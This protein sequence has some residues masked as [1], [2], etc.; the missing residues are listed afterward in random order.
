MTYLIGI[1]VGTTNCK[2][3]AYRADGSL[4]MIASRP[5]VT[6]HVEP[7]KAEFDPDQIWQAVQEALCEVLAE[8]DGA[9]IAGIAVASMG[10]A[11]VLLDENGRWIHRS[12]AWFV[13]R[14]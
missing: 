2:A 5:T 4:Q 8:M 14:T 11:G 13:T 7:G 6:H 3:A 9:P 1:D 12:I 10:A